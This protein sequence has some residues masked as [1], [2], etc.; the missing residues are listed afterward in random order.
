MALTCLDELHEGEVAGEHEGVDHDVGALAAADLFEGLGDDEGVEAE[1][2]FVDAA[3]G[4]GERAGLAVGDHDDLL[5]VFV[6]AGEDALGEAQAFAGVGV[7]G[8]DFD[9]GELGD[10]DLFGGVVEEDEVEGVAGELGADE[11][12]ERHG[13]ALGGGEAVFAVEDHGVGA[14]EQDDGG[15]GGLV[16]GLVDVEVGV[17][18]VERR[19][20]FAFDGGAMPSRAK[21]LER[22]AVMS[23]LRV[24]P[25]S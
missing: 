4:E 11:V 6:L 19:V 12:G 14:V 17:L 9:A 16:V 20:L 10:G 24:S 23:R 2:V 13:D 3:V 7:V 1:G 25:N 15:A 18:D 5:H 22:V 8:A 21:T